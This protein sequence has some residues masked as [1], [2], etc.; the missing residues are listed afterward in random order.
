[1]NC[2]LHVSLGQCIDARDF[3]SLYCSVDE[4]VSY[5]ACQIEY[6][7]TPRQGVTLDTVPVWKYVENQCSKLPIV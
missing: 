7:K 5:V 2:S 4:S 1:M 3:Y 6:K